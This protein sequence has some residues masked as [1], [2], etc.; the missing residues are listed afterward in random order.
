MFEGKTAIITGAGRGIGAA[1]ARRLAKEGARVVVSDLDADLA[2][3]V[4]SELGTQAVSHCGDVCHPG[5][6]QDLVGRAVDAFGRL[7]IIVNNAGYLWPGAI[8][9]MT[10][11]QF[12]SL[13]D[14]HVVA[15]FRI[16]RAAAAPMIASAKADAAD[17]R[18]VFRK[19]VNVSSL[20][21]LEGSP[22]SVNYGAA[23][24]GVIGLTKSLAKEWGR[25]RINVNC[26]AFG[27]IATRLTDPDVAR[28]PEL[29]IGERNVNIGS[30][31][32]QV[33]EIE[34]TIPLGRRGTADEAAGAIRFLCSPDA[35]YVTGQVLVVSGGL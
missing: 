2:R 29:R 22:M 33:P 25:Y 16:L 12:E 28:D 19:V 14:V 27:L 10:D 26:V 17:G 9:R 24:A 34:R 1:L 15:P 6:A 11:D 30:M 23:K 5:F 21:A 13:L 7:D 3:A 18:E 35:D 4:A 20:L 31:G 8:H 32:L